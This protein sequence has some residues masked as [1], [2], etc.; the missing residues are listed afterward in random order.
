MQA[1]IKNTTKYFE[2]K[3]KGKVNGENYYI[4]KI[5]NCVSGYFESALEFKQN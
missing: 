5:N 2:A 3:L 4:L 1:K